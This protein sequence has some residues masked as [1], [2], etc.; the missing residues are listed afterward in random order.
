MHNAKCLETPNFFREI[1]LPFTDS[2]YRAMIRSPV[3]YF[4]RRHIDPMIVYSAWLST[5]LSKAFKIRRFVANS[6]DGASFIICSKGADCWEMSFQKDIKRHHFRRLKRIRFALKK[7]FLNRVKQVQ[8]RNHYAFIVTR[9]HDI[10]LELFIRKY[11]RR[12]ITIKQKLNMILNLL[13]G[14]EHYLGHKIIHGNLS[15][16]SIYLKFDSENIAYLKHAQPFVTLINKDKPII[17]MISEFTHYNLLIKPNS[18][19]FAKKV[20]EH[21]GREVDLEDYVHPEGRNYFHYPDA[22]RPFEV[23]HPKPKIGPASDIY[24]MGLIIYKLYFWK[25]PYEFRDGCQGEH[26]KVCMVKHRHFIK[27]LKKKKMDGG[28][29]KQCVLMLVE[30]MVQYNPMKRS[31]PGEARK[32]FLECLGGLGFDVPNEDKLK[33]LTD[34]G[35]REQDLIS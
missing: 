24:A 6:K 29:V 15:T 35:L 30:G 11:R 18:V 34:D 3:T 13:T 16:S 4:Y 21:G 12:A 20:H 2:N 25:L 28:D 22:F 14:M 26:I 8:V 19:P 23:R 33:K 7:P 9:P 27:Y 10:N 5:R 31:L 32:Q 17:P 1:I